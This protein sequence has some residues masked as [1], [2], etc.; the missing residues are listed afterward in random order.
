MNIHLVYIICR[1]TFS[2]H[3]IESGH[4]H[5]IYAPRDVI[6]NIYTIY[7]ITAKNIHLIYTIRKVTKNIQ[8][9]CKEVY[10]G[11]FVSSVLGGLG[12]TCIALL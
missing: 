9:Y 7:T 10:F 8:F 4:E 2:I 6:V 3:I 12:T 1:V 5:S 11:L